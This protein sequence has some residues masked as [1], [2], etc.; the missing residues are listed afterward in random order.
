MRYPFI[1]IFALL[2]LVLMHRL[3]YVKKKEQEGSDKFWDREAKAD[4]VRKQDIS[5][6]D[7]I[8]IPIELLPFGADSSAD[9]A[10]LEDTVRRLDSTKILNLNQYTNTDLKLQYGA[11]NLPFLSECDDRY[12]T[13]IRALYQWAC[14]LMEH[15]YIEEAVTVA[16]YSIDTG[17]DLSGIYYMLTDYYSLENDVSSLQDLMQ[18]AENLTG[19]TSGQ[20]RDYIQ[21]ALDDQEEA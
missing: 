5:D 19:I 15:G 2:C 14:L 8:Y 1:I 7:Y 18:Q 6:L 9:V 12:T 21:K 17:A 3:R 11:A 4:K 20:I 16:K 13:L 10:E